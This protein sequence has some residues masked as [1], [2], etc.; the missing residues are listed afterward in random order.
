[1][2]FFSYTDA[3]KFTGKNISLPNKHSSLFCTVFE[4]EYLTVTNVC[5]ISLYG[6]GEPPEC[7]NYSC[8]PP[9]LDVLSVTRDSKK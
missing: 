1:M 3:S 2:F 9:F 7:L 5:L 6:S 4:T 8:V